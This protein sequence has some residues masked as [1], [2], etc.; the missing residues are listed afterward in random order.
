MHKVYTFQIC[1][2]GKIRK[3]RG[4]LILETHSFDGKTEYSYKFPLKCLDDRSPP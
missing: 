3:G 2:S 1:F 4:V